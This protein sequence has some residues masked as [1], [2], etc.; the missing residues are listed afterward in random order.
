[1]S[2]CPQCDHDTLTLDESE[3]MLRCMLC[4][5][6]KKPN[7]NNRCPICG[8]LVRNPDNIPNKEKFKGIF[9]P[10]IHG[11]GASNHGNEPEMNEIATR[12]RNGQ[13]EAP[14]SL[15]QKWRN[16]QAEEPDH[17]SEEESLREDNESAAERSAMA[18]RIRGAKY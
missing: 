3:T 2:K 1:M 5:F 10:R 8:K 15:V 9:A 16:D 17:D 4:G 11:H 14:Y 13:G 7:Y 12:K 6:E 18:R